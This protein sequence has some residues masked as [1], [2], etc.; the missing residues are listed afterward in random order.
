[1]MKTLTDNL[2]TIYKLKETTNLE[3]G[4]ERTWPEFICRWLSMIWKSSGGWGILPDS[5][6]D[7]TGMLS[8]E[9]SKA[10][11]ETSWLSTALQMKKSIMQ[12]YILFSRAHINGEGVS[13]PII[14][15][16]LNVAR[17]QTINASLR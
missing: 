11:V 9:I 5:S 14:G 8:T 16:G 12:A 2:T 3:L 17:M 1:M 7:Q 4:V 10:P 6:L 13:M 15:K